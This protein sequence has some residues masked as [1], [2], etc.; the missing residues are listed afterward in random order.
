[1]IKIING[2]ILNCTED[3]IVHQVNV[4]GAMGGGVARQLADKYAG[5]E[6]TYA[7]YCHKHKNRYINLCGN[8]FYYQA[9]DKT[10]ANMF[11]QQENFDTDYF[12][13]KV[14]LKDIA[15]FAK[16]NEL[17]VC[18]PYRYRLRNSKRRL[19]YCIKYNR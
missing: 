19:E 8:V 10:I 6:E 1:M 15:K 3:I 17:S 2:D 16:H 14:A 4:A 11:S 13:M 5:L 7:E 18:I 9:T 12:N